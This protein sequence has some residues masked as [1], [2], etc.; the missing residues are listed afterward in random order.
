VKAGDLVR[1]KRSERGMMG[2]IVEIHVNKTPIVM[3]DDGRCGKCIPAYLEVIND[4][5]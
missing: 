4:N 2:I 3:W 5:N 1:H